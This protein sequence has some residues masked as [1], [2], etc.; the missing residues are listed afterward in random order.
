MIKKGLKQALLLSAVLSAGGCTS[1]MWGSGTAVD[2]QDIYHRLGEDKVHAFGYARAD[3]GQLKQGSLVM[4]GERYWY[5]VEPQASERLLP[6]LNAKLQHSY[7]IFSP[8]AN[9]EQLVELPVT[10]EDESG[11][12]SSSF[13]L[14]YPVDTSQNNKQ[15]A[16]EKTALQALRFR[17]ISEEPSLMTYERC[18]SARGQL[19]DKPLQV[20]QN[21]RFE[22]YVP[23]KLQTAERKTV[24][25]SG[26]KLLRNIVL[27]PLTLVGD[28]VVTVIAVPIF[29]IS[30]PKLM[31]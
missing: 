11:K 27:T 12:F 8:G 25:K 5:V 7:Q 9:K 1:A 30:K 3:S 17:P 4:M 31:F 18:F 22:Q 15:A 10:I 23:V 24:V 6:V 16:Q 21:Y 19:Y 26:S 13:C 2:T 14:R 28:A 29:A 20:K